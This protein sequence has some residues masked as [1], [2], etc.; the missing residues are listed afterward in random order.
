[1]DFFV[2]MTTH[3]PPGTPPDEIDD[4]GAARSTTIHPL[5]A[6]SPET[7]C[8]HSAA[9][10]LA[11]RPPQSKPSRIGRGMFNAFIARSDIPRQGGFADRYGSWPRKEPGGSEPA[12][13]PDDDSEALLGQDV[14]N[15][16]VA[17]NVVGPAEQQDDRMTV[18]RPGI[19]VCDAQVAARTSC[20]GFRM[21]VGAGGGVAL[22]SDWVSDVQAA[23]DTAPIAAVAMKPNYLLLK[24]FTAPLPSNLSGRDISSGTGRQPKCWLVTSRG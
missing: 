1:M 11:L 18:R 20:T 19:G 9:T 14:G 6:T 13:I 2:D 12:Q 17:V 23:N 8:G 5:T 4:I 22:S 3:V 24:P 15:I 21:W 10:A 7:R 16:G